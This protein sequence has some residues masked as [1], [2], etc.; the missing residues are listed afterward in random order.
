MKKR[1][2]QHLKWILLIFI[3]TTLIIVIEQRNVI[4]PIS[5]LFTMSFVFSKSQI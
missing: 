1:H 3:L 2:R 5:F 4:L